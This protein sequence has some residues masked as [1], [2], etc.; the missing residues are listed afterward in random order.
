MKMK[1]ERIVYLFTTVFIL[2]AVSAQAAVTELFGQ[3][4]TTWVNA[5]G[6]HPTTNLTAV[7]SWYKNT[8]TA[9]QKV[10]NVDGSP[11][12][13]WWKEKGTSRRPKAINDYE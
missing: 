3:D 2:L 11:I 5:D 4:H 12:G 10:V 8:P 6:T 13:S 7:G 1:K 9:W